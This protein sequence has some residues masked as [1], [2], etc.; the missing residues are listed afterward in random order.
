M[1]KAPETLFRPVGVFAGGRAVGPVFVER[2]DAV[3]WAAAAF[4]QGG[5]WRWTLAVVPAVAPGGDTHAAPGKLHPTPL[6][7]GRLP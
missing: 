1:K 4:P 7:E 2:R 3:A 6:S 5:P